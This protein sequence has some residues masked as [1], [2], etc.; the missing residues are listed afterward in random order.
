MLLIAY[1]TVLH[2]YTYTTRRFQSIYLSNTIKQHPMDTHTSCDTHTHGM[3]EMT[4]ISC[5]THME[6]MRCHTHGMDEMTHTH[7]M[8][9]MRYTSCD[10]HTWNG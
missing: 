9:E 4:H 10:T 1:V 8:D 2:P 7:G 5:D 6:W 3:D